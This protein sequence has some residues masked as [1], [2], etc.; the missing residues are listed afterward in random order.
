MAGF[1]FAI[2]DEG[3][4]GIKNCAKYGAYST[5]VNG[6]ASAKLPFEGTLADYCSMNEGDNVY[7]F[8]KRKIYG[9]GVMKKVGSDCKYN[10]YPG[11]SKL[12]SSYSFD[13]TIQSQMLFG[14]KRENM[15]N[16]W[17]CLFV[18]CPEFYLDG[19]D[20][21]DLLTYKPQ[22]LRRIRT[23]WKT[24]FIKVDDLENDTIKEFLYL[25][26]LGSKNVITFNDS[27]HRRINSIVNSNY[28]I[29]PCDLIP[30][31][32]DATGFALKHEMAIE[33]IL[34]DLLNKGLSS[35]FGKWDYVTHQL[36]A[37]PFKPID[38]MDKIDVFAYKYRVVENSRFIT[39]YLIL[40]LKA[41]VA[42]DDTVIQVS[43]YVDYIC[44]EYAYGDYSLIEAYVL[45][46]DISQIDLKKAK[47]T[48]SRVYNIGSHPII[49][50]QW[51]D[52]HLV[53]Y[54]V[55][56]SSLKFDKIDI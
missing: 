16:H 14:R 30:G 15:S 22:N 28:L 7:F 44:K 3:L 19:I 54:E 27:V 35:I 2:G 49:S 43:K 46:N 13:S 9:V 26:N 56:G 23:F 8:Y 32:L 48:A 12:V 4:E 33:A 53:K 50:K 10:N 1:I 25:K 18:P 41:N 55:D 38:Y 29:N 47:A 20:M 51:C 24:S 21:D 6:I 39:K 37:S 52:L 5:F 34:V 40:E 36:C 45:A 17:V 42:D 31:C 11:A